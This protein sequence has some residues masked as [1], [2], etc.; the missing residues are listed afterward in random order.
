[1][2]L[3]PISRADDYQF[4]PDAWD[5]RGWTVRTEMDDEKVGKV[6]D[7]LLD[8]HGA[9]RYL[10]VDLGFLRRH[11]LVPLDYAFA[12]RATE[13]VRIEGMKKDGLEDV[14]EYSLEPESLDEGYERRLDRVY[15]A[16]RTTSTSR[17]G[18]GSG[19]LPTGADAD[20]ELELQRMGKLEGDYQVAGEDPRGWDVVTA[21]GREVGEVAELLMD[22]GA[23]KAR[24]L[25]VAVDEKELDLEPVDRHILL[26]AERVRLDRN[27]KR[28]IVSG[29]LTADVARYPQYSGLPVRA[30]TAYEVDEFFERAGTQNDTR[31]GSDDTAAPRGDASMRHFYRTTPRTDERITGEEYH[32]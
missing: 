29:L 21:D 4:P 9:L 8:A 24:F 7:M 6:E 2:A 32:G 3:R 26:P 30:R 31:A 22:P 10:E 20:A 25:D 16:A 18:S 14:P 23:M 5:V 12:D 19:P 13:T 28:V 1:M 27:K 17:S 15:G 11:V